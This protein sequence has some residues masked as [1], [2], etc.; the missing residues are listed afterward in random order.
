MSSSVRPASAAPAAAASFVAS[1]SASSRSSTSAASRSAQLEHL[2]QGRGGS[3]APVHRLEHPPRG[4]PMVPGGG[5]LLQRRA[6]R[7]LLRVE[8]EGLLERV[9]RARHVAQA[10]HAHRP[11]SRE[12]LGLLAASGQRRV[13][14]ERLGEIGPEPLRLEQRGGER[15]HVA[16]R[17]EA[18]DDRAARRD[19]ARGVLR[20]ARPNL[21]GAHQELAS[22]PGV[23]RV[24]RPLLEQPRVLRGIAAGLVEGGERLE[25]PAPR[26]RSEE[27]LVRGDRAR[28][29]LELRGQVGQLFV[30]ADAPVAVRLDAGDALEDLA[31][32]PRVLVALV[33]LAEGIRGDEDGVGRRLGRGEDA[34]Q[35]RLRALR[36]ASA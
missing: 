2:E 19:G 27:P 14:R 33:D 9:E 22:P 26:R 20:L 35:R 36:V 8:G 7:P 30:H 31:E 29:V 28:H 32:A 23:G 6:R 10:D 17:P 5:E 21:R 13:L 16:R 24:G 1:R 4:Q 25:R 3:F 12:D 15:E 18:I 34:G 11:E